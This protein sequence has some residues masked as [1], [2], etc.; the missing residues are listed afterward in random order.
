MAFDALGM[1]LFVG[2]RSPAVI[3]SFD[4][5]TGTLLGQIPNCADADDVFYDALRK[6]VYV[7]GGQG[8]VAILTPRGAPL[9]RLRMCA[10]VSARTALFS[11]ELDRL[12]VAARAHVPTRA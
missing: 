6:R 1:R 4:T 11:P 5:G 3:A 2:Y 12:F 7:S 8:L 9:T 10:E